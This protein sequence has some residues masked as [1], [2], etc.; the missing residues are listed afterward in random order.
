MFTYALWQREEFVAWRWCISQSRYLT[1]KLSWKIRYE[2][3]GLDYQQGLMSAALF[4][5]G[6]TEKTGEKKENG[7]EFSS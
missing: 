3:A 1:G 6:E 4:I 7:K 5:K 2:G